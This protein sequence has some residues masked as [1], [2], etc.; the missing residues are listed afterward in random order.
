MFRVLFLDLRYLTVSIIFLDLRY[1]T[2]SIIFL[3]QQLQPYVWSIS[4]VSLTQLH[5]L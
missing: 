2:V 4:V 5:T 3:R 1:L